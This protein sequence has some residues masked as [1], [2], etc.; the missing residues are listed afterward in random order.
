MWNA[1]PFGRGAWPRFGLHRWIACSLGALALAGCVHQVASEDLAA[2]SRAASDISQQSDLAFSE[3][4]RLARQVAVDQFVRAGLPGLSE[5]H[6]L[7]AIPKESAD[8]WIDSLTTLSD[9][10]TVLASL[11]DPSR[12][13]QTSDALVALGQ[14]M[15]TGTIGLKISPG[16][17][18]A[19]SSLGGALVEARAQQQARQILLSTDPRVQQLVVIMADSIG[20]N[21]GEGLRGTVYTLAND[22]LRPIRSAYAAAATSHDEAEQRR[23]IDLYLQGLDTRDAQLRSLANLRSS[24]INL[25][26]AHSA[27]AKGS[28]ATAGAL[29]AQIERR[30]DETKRIYA[31]VTKNQET[32]SNGNQ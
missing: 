26:A 32:S 3:S 30:L 31:E 15:Q 23:L 22:S 10:G 11:V 2:F 8:A 20:A 17:A 21:D 9:Y 18:T 6:F 16:V 25:G 19:F 1:M 29:I 13:V 12:S 4:N 5:D 7:G 24:I 14:K 27:A 28:P